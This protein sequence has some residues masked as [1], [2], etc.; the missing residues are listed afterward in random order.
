MEE[1]K[2]EREKRIFGARGKHLF[3]R[4]FMKFNKFCS[5]VRYYDSS[6]AFAFVGNFV[7]VVIS[8]RMR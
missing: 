8:V 5:F 1:A 2:S 7:L 4:T 3:V 6:L